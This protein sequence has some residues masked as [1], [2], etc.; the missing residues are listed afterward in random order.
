MLRPIAADSSAG[1]VDEQRPRRTARQR[2]EPGGPAA[3]EQV[4]EAAAAQR[5]RPML[6][7]AEQ[8]LAGAVAGGAGGHAC[9]RLDPAAAMPPGDD[10]QAHPVPAPVAAGRARTGFSTM[11]PTCSRSTL[12]STSSTARLGSRPSWNGP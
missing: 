8:R 1:L 4:E 7:D 6:E 5:R 3:G 10:P 11:A 9:G 12:P 2:L